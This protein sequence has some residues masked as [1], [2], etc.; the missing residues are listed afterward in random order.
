MRQ[1]K[2][3]DIFAFARVIK[4]SGIRADLNAFIQKLSQQENADREK[5]GIDTIMMIAEALVEKKAE[6]AIYEA[7]APILEMTPQQVE[8]LPPSE[9]FADLKQLAKDNDLES[10]FGSV[11]RTLGSK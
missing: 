9:L 7:L 8:D 10:F 4:A 5:V 11:F 1:L 2:T 3:A 6:A